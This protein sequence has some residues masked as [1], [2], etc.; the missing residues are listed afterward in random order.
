MLYRYDNNNNIDSMKIV[1]FQLSAYDYG[2]KDLI[3][4]MISSAKKDVI[5]NNLDELISLYYESFIDCLS[6]LK[7][8][9]TKFTREKFDKILLES[10]PL[11]F[12]QC[13]MM[14]EIIKS[15]RGTAP[16]LQSIKNKN[17]FLNTGKGKIYEDKLIHVLQTFVKRGWLVE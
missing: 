12:S 9:Q 3:F 1:D 2:V 11:K 7:I 14:T 15:A 6:L 5:D 13:I 4:F 8:E 17:E 10:A 16:E